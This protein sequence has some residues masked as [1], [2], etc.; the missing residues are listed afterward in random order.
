MFEC[1]NEERKRP[2]LIY[3]YVRTMNNLNNK[4]DTGKPFKLK[5]SVTEKEL[6]RLYANK[7]IDCLTRA[8]QECKMS[9]A[10][11]E[12]IP[13][14]TKFSSHFYIWKKKKID[15]LEHERTNGCGPPKGTSLCYMS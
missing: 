4:K 13:N 14:F 10:I 5:G 2:T 11:Q 7:L 6:K 9:E 3:L 12:E 1:S 15:Q 8:S